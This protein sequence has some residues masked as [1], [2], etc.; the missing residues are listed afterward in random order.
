MNGY[1]SYLPSSTHLIVLVLES[2]LKT[3]FG[4][5]VCEELVSGDVERSTAVDA[6]FLILFNVF[7]RELLQLSAVSD[8]C[9]SASFNPSST[10]FGFVQ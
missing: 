6:A 4:G 10:N 2:I 9:P 1:E 7:L 8:L 3:F 5:S